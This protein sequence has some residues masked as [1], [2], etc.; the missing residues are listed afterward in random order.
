MQDVL[1]EVRANS[2]LVGV[3]S[4]QVHARLGAR[5]FPLSQRSASALPQAQSRLLWVRQPLV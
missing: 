3:E 5:C 1:I 4:L 2:P